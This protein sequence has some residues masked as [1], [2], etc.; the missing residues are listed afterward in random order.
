MRTE[1]WGY[2]LVKTDQGIAVLNS[3]MEVLDLVT[4]IAPEHTKTLDFG[5]GRQLRRESR[6]PGIEAILK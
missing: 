3:R 5:E 1:A 2:L 4:I 6:V